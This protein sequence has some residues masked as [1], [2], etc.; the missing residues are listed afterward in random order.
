VLLPLA[1][2]AYMGAQRPVTR[3]LV[4][5]VR[6]ARNPQNID[7]DKRSAATKI[8]LFFTGLWQP[9]SQLLGVQSKNRKSKK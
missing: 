9:I 1:C 8:L 2:L 7:H 6:H 3:R 5:P 4:M